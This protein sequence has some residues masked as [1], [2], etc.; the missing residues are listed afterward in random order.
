MFVLGGDEYYGYCKGRMIFIELDFNFR[1]YSIVSSIQYSQAVA[2]E[3]NMWG[4]EDGGRYQ[5]ARPTPRAVCVAM[6]R[7]LRSTV[8]PCI[9]K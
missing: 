3:R 1:V 7:G 2:H 6:Q 5:E 8:I 4:W 9:R